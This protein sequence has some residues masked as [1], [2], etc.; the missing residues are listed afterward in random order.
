[1]IYTD[2]ALFFTPF[3]HQNGKIFLSYCVC[4]TGNKRGGDSTAY[5]V[6]AA[7]EAAGF[8]VFMDC[9][10]EGGDDWGTVINTSLLGA[11][12]MVALSSTHFAKLRPEGMAM[13]GTSWTLNEVRSFMKKKP[14]MLFPLLHSG[15][16]PPDALFVE[17][18]AIEE[19]KL[20]T[21][22]ETAMERLVASIKRKLQ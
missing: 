9:N 15:E 8:E 4:D 21:G 10:L 7:L 20:S 14:K 13:A 11:D 17:C 3:L 19:V 22:V 6:K 16:W 5:Q 12:A 18:N 2:P 1:M